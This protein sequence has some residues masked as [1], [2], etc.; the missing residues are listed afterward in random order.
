MQISRR[1]AGCR[2]QAAA[3][4]SALMWV[5]DFIGDFLETDFILNQ[6]KRPWWIRALWVVW[7]L[8]FVVVLIAFLV[9]R[10]LA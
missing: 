1:E 8:P 4:A 3:L 6:G 10:Y 9:D 2:H 7:L 5:W